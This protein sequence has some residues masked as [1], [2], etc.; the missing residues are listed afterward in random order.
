MFLITPLL[1]RAYAPA[2]FGQLAL[3]MTIASYAAAAGCLRLDLA[4]SSSRAE[5]RDALFVLCLIAALAFAGLTGLLACLPWRSW[6]RSDLATLSAEPWLLAAV[7]A[8]VGLYQAVSSDLVGRSGFSRLAVV[9]ASQ[10]VGFAILAPLH[11]IGL[12]WALVVSY[13]V[14]ASAGLRRF[15][16]VSLAELGAVAKEH[17]R[18][19]LLSLPGAICDV[20]ACSAVVV[21]ISDAYGLAQLGQFSQVQR[22]IGAPLL[23]VSASL[24]QVY[25]RRATDDFQAGQPLRPLLLRTARRA[26]LFTLAALAVVALFGER[27]LHLW[28]G[29]G[30]RVDTPFLLLTLGGLAIRVCVSPFSSI[31][32]TTGRL[33]TLLGWQIV[34]LVTSFAVLPIA[35]SFLALDDFLAVYVL[36]E[37]V[38]YGLYFWLIHRATGTPGKVY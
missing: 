8:G 19:P 20:L 37:S 26:A 30:W 13:L 29:S 3:I 24:F 22:T 23:L 10:G 31:L 7:V 2:D 17:R 32:V 18:F 36:H 25:L 33:G 6:S 38:L 9:R 1:A 12:T 34:Y 35:A 15:A 4:L 27:V 5:Q 14:A 21:V 16:R 28:L 11:A